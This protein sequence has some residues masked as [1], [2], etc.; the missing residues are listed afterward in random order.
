THGMM[1]ALTYAQDQQ[2][3]DGRTQT[4]LR[5]GGRVYVSDRRLTDEERS[6]GADVLSRRGLARPARA[7][8]VASAESDGAGRGRGAAPM[9][10]PTNNIAGVITRRVQARASSMGVAY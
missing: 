8:E 5:Q 3:A 10:A 2:L 9:A 7:A 1:T 4:I 6:E